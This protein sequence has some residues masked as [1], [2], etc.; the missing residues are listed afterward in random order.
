MD[1]ALDNENSVHASWSG[2]DEWNTAPATMKRQSPMCSK[3]K[4]N[5][6]FPTHTLAH[7]HTHVLN[8]N[9]HGNQRVLNKRHSETSRLFTAR[10][11]PTQAP[12]NTI[13]HVVGQQGTKKIC[14]G[15]NHRNGLLPPKKQRCIYSEQPEISRMHLSPPLGF[16]EPGNHMARKGI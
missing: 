2:Q 9:T 6:H 10:S 4:G 15:W 16:L 12:G 5:C 13:Q 14:I 3:K 7:T 8:A 11:L 1:K